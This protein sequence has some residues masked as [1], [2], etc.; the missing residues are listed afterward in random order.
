MT[1][2]ATPTGLYFPTGAATRFPGVSNATTL[3]A[4]TDKSC[5]IGHVYWEGR[6]ASKVVSS[7]G[8]QIR[9]LPGSS[10]TFANGATTI[11]VGIQDVD[12]TNGP[13]VRGDGTFD[14]KGT[15][16]GVTDT[17]T[18]STVKTVNMSSGSK[19]I[20]HGDLIAVVIDM[21]A[22]GGA[23][24]VQTT[25]TNAPSSVGGRPVMT[26]FK[27]STWQTSGGIP[28]MVIVADDGTLGVFDSTVPMVNVPG[29]TYGDSTN[30]DE[31]GL[32][33]QVPWDC[34]ID[35][36]FVEM[37]CGS[38]ANS[39][40]SIALYSDPTGTP[41]VVSG[42]SNTILGENFER[43]G[44]IAWLQILLPTE[45]SLTANTDYLLAVKGTGSSSITLNSYVLQD[46]NLRKFFTG[47][48]TL[49]KATRNNGS[50]AFT[51]ESP[52]ITMY[53]MGVRISEF[54][55]SGGTVYPRSGLQG[56][57]EGMS[58]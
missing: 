36:L 19:T 49:K 1:L 4:A 16:T 32:I 3:N 7:S 9:F 2:A 52:A 38:G 30:P 24:S 54:H 35:A 27:S 6:A 33:F 5:M 55:D 31:R 17:I 21:T 47:G 13:P 29:E 45:V 50:G 20:A 26:Q 15:L 56:I 44:S 11:D 43:N 51:A 25:N 40:S 58:R 48:T 34:K 39:D 14:V 42:T 37:S 23:D 53:Q 57:N 41:A 46:T 28:N 18:A 12:P 22:R 8:G 10:I